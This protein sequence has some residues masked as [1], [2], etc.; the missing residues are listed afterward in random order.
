MKALNWFL[1]AGQQIQMAIGVAL[2]TAIGLLIAAQ[3]G[4]VWYFTGQLDKREARI[5]EL[6]DQNRVCLVNVN[7]LQGALKGQNEAIDKL[8]EVTQRALGESRAAVAAAQKAAEQHRQ[9][10]IELINSKPERPDDLCWSAKAL[11][12]QSRVRK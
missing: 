5:A 1:G 9:T 3:A 6:L 2:I 10:A 12:D 11:I 4:T 7:T 8:G